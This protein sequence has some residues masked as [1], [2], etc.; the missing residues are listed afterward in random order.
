M[1]YGRP[2]NHRAI[3]SRIFHDKKCRP[4]NERLIFGWKECVAI[5]MGLTSITISP[6]RSHIRFS[7]GEMHTNDSMSLAEME[8][9]KKV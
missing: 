7:M 2:A 9:G 3:I 8:E 1:R 4:S 5:D 6:G